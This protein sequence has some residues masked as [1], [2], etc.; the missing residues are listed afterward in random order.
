MSPFNCPSL[1]T[2]LSYLEY[3]YGVWHPTGG[4]GAVCEAMARVA[5]SMGV[6]FR[7]A[8]EVRRVLIE[9]GR[10]VGVISDS[11]EHRADALVINADFADAMTRL[12]PD[13]HRRAW[14]DKKLSKKRYSC[15]T[16]MLYLGLEGRDDDLPHHTIFLAGDY[17]DNLRD[18][19][20]R[21]RLS[22]NPSMYVQ[23]ASVTDPTLAP[24]GHSTLYV[25]A[26][27][28]HDHPNIDWDAQRQS[29]RRTVLDQLPKLGIAGVEERIRFEQVYTPNDW[30]DGMHVYRG[31]T[32]NLAH[33][34]TQM[35]HLRPRNRFDEIPGTYLVGGGT[36]PGSG[37]PVIYES[38]RISS[39]LL[40]EDLGVNAGA[41]PHRY[42]SV[43]DA[44]P[45][46]APVLDRAAARVG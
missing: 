19:E 8:D 6:R 3:D 40:L 33:S 21:H 17:P 31:A 29:F 27:V 37:L 12:V 23:N 45:R 15:S 41:S 35:L 30:R 32:F 10:A 14:R 16:F 24:A 38:A 5:R 46:L 25:L 1:F 2:I 18:I 7:L 4:C 11:G 28:S 20:K 13:H 9:N 44:G 39:R 43:R 42:R 36:H 34:L 26:P 22:H